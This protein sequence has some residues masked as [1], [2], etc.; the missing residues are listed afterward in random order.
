MKRTHPGRP[1]IDDH[2]DSIEVGVTLPVK[3]FDRYAKLALRAD[4]SVPEIIRRELRE[5]TR[6]INIDKSSL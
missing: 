2:D 6:R 3:Q 4:V 1:P 5:K